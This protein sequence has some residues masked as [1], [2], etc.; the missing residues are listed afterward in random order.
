MRQGQV[1]VG[2]AAG[3]V[4]VSTVQRRAEVRHT[5]SRGSARLANHT[6]GPTAGTD[7]G[8]QA[9]PRIRHRLQVARDS[10]I[11]PRR[12]LQDVTR[13]RG[14]AL[15]EG[16]AR[17]GGDLGQGFQIGPGP[18]GIDVV[19][20]QRRHTTPVVDARRDQSC[21]LGRRDQIRR[22]LDSHPRPEH[23]ARHRD[24]RQ[25]L[26]ELGV[27]D[28]AH[29]GVG[30]GSKVLD[31]DFLDVAEDVVYLADL[32]QRVGTLGE[33]LPDSDEDPRGER[34]GHPSR[35]DK[36][37]L[38]DLRVLVRTAVVTVP[39]VREETACRGLEHH[40]H[41][42]GDRLES[43]HLFGTHHPGIEVGQQ[44]GLFQNTDGSGTDIVE[45][46]AVAAFVE[47]LLSF[48]PPVFWPV[49]QGEQCFFAT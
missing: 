49:P 22:G 40:A 39:P 34:Y 29:R 1:V 37:P 4:G 30:L 16:V 43:R 19:G 35:V 31:D 17:G 26:L 36:Y 20:R 6:P 5:P 42:W 24:C 25:E 7:V 33:T 15:G 18:F 46:G 28:P 48:G 41:R 32:D 21:T 45:G 11:D 10:R 9:G 8:G 14:D 47:P 2:T 38:A 44:A 13:L 23:D 3:R 12:A 27:G